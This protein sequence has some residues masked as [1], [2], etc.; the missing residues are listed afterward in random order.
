MYISI[1]LLRRPAR[2]VL[3]CLSIPP[4]SVKTVLIL[5]AIVILSLVAFTFYL[6]GV[7][8]KSRIDQ[9]IRKYLYAIDKQIST[10]T[11]SRETIRNLKIILRE[12]T[13][14]QRMDHDTIEN[15]NRQ[16][17]DLSARVAISKEKINRLYSKVKDLLRQ[18]FHDS[19]FL[20]TRYYENLD[21]NRKTERLYRVVKSQIED[22]TSPRSIERLDSLLN[23]AY[24]GIMNRLTSVSLDLKERELMLLRLLL[25]G[26]SAKSTAAIL[27]DSHL[28]IGQRKKRLLDKI[29]KLSPSLLD[30][31]ETVLN[32]DF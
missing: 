20:Y 27:K 4:D 17:F 32:S 10:E 19:D 12:K 18:R 5:T 1:V 26:F 29:G 15:L 21:D 24:S 13:D 8:R 2:V 30:E 16:L 22:F 31:L 14:N 9:K 7:C 25:A 28:N 6:L 11:L 23:E 3:Y